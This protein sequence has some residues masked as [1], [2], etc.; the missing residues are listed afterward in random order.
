V[1]PTKYAIGLSLCLTGSLSNY[2]LHFQEVADMLLEHINSAGGFSDG[3]KLEYVIRDDATNPQ[4][5]TQVDTDLVNNAK[6]PAIMGHCSSG[7]TVPGSSVTIPAKVVLISPSAT[8]PRVTTL[9]DNDYVFRTAPS[10]ALQGVVLAKLAND[11]GYRKISIIARNDAYGGGLATELQKAF[12]RMGGQVSKIALY[13]ES[14]TDFTAQITEANQDNPDAISI[15]AFQEV[16][17]LLTQ[18]VK[19]GVTKFDLLADGTKDQ[20]T[21]DKLVPILG[22]ELLNDKRGSAPA[23]AKT[24]GAA[25]FETLYKEYRIKKNQ[26]AEEVFVYTPNT[27]DAIFLL[28]LAIQKAIAD[29]QKVTGEALHD[30]LRSVANPPGELVRVHE[31]KRA[32]EL[33]KQGQEIDY[34]GASGAVNLDEKGDTLSPVRIWSLANGKITEGQLCQLDLKDGVFTVTNC[35]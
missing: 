25:Q 10:D 13:E 18:M 26:P 4:Q 5:A 29:K 19:A 32:V 17:S 31:W 3:A 15:I 2:G 24:D 20:A 33:L 28:A 22:A 30:A 9:E 27:Y 35:E 34:E 14:A 23:S 7:A 11:K 6:V 8:S 21:Y 1:A 16:E 12:E